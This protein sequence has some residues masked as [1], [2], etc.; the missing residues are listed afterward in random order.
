MRVGCKKRHVETARVPR[1]L[2]FIMA[3]GFYTACEVAAR[4]NYDT[5]G[6][7]TKA[8]ISRLSP[9][10][11][12]ALFRNTTTDVWNE[13]QA[14]YKHQIEM[15]QCGVPRSGLW[16]WLMSS[17]QPKGHLI[18]PERVD[19]GPSLVRPY[20]LGRQKS[21]WETQVNHWQLT[22][23]VQGNTYTPLDTSKTYGDATAG[24]GLT[25]GSRSIGANNRCLTV[26]SSYAG[27][28]NLHPDYFLPDKRIHVIS[29][30]AITGAFQLT[31]FKIVYAARN[32]DVTLDVEVT[33]DQPAS[34][35][36]GG[37]LANAS[38]PPNA[39][40]TTGLVLLGINN[41]HD[42]EQWCRNMI[43]VNTEKRVPFWYQFF[44]NARSTGSEYE[45]VFQHLATNNEYFKIFQDLPQAERN[46]QDEV[47]QRAEWIHAFLFGERISNKQNLD[48]W[49]SL[50][51]ITSLA[52]GAW[53]AGTSKWDGATVDPGTGGQAMF[54][55]ANMIGVLPQ[56]KD[57]GRFTDVANQDF[58]INTF[59]E[60]TI[61]D[62]VRA[63]KGQGKNA[64][65]VDVW[66]T[67]NAALEFQRAFVAYSKDITGDIVRINQPEF[68]Q[69]EWGFPYTKFRLYKPQGVTVNFITDPALDD[70]ANAFATGLESLGNYLWV[71][72]WGNGG[73][74]Y[75]GM[76]GS[77]RKQYTVGEINDLSRVDQ[78]F[79]CVM[80]NPTIKRTLTSQI[81]TAVV[82]CPLNSIVIGNYKRLVSGVAAP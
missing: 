38:F 81:T 60:N 7:V 65:E 73:S 70:F 30:N 19:R 82:E 66:G 41:I 32:T 74:I 33:L 11:M 24:P 22:G 49:G 58:P 80:E 72:D 17:A 53:N 52:G 40:A 44:R 45:K 75:P 25:A 23:N 79:S 1:T 34:Q 29:R 47:R 39:T 37:T 31:Q 20:I 57:C 71:C 6:T 16:E 51:A 8:K 76:L 10:Q 77:N 5:V 42:V 4:N 63:R 26:Q 18:T 59:L 54:Y 78:S 55:R 68:G 62:I 9:A 50:D 64:S 14:F 13:F 69:N 21:L 56:L 67:S 28:M 48:N 36:E 12:E 43:N 15:A 46:R 61:Y 3:S 35:S 27:T 2:F